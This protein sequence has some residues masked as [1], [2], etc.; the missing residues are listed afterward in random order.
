MNLVPKVSYQDSV[1][2]STVTG[3]PIKSVSCMGEVTWD[4]SSSPFAREKV[5]TSLI[6]GY[7]EFN[8]CREGRKVR[9]RTRF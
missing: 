2:G 6:E 3:D 8:R 5:Y 7:V 4:D 9:G 1:V